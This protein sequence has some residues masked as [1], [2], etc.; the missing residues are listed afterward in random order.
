MS[1]YEQAAWDNSL[2]RLHEPPG[3]GLLPQRAKDAV[4]SGKVAATQFAD[5]HLPVETVKA[6]V[7]KVMD[8]ALE[9]TF[10]PALRTA[11]ADRALKAYQ[12][13]HDSLQS[14]DDLKQL[15][16]RELDKFRRRKGVYIAT[17]AV[18]AS[19]TS[20]VVTG[21]VV[22]TTVS[23]GAT[24]GTVVAAVAGDTV[25]SLAVMGR[26]VGSVAV[27]YGYDVRLPDE[28][29]FAMGVLTLGTAGSLEAKQA[30][31]AALSRLTQ[32]M[33]RRATW[34][35]LNR[36]V[37]VR[38]IGRVYQALGLKLTQRKLAQTVP[39][40]GI[41]INAALSASMTRHVYQRAEDV[42]RV[43]FLSEKYGL[44]ATEWLRMD[45]DGGCDSGESADG[46]DI[47]E[48]LQQ[49]IERSEQAD[50]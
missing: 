43:R 27:R 35:Q 11:N 41:G 20:V 32:Q 25:A 12:R 14:L 18:Q 29:L 13:R 48:V 30:A 10:T 42:Y 9:L 15:D 16:V 33:M 38:T 6:M 22:S 19:A 5:A 37:L 17:S 31:L 8:G 7:E 46:V 40:V 47:A 3:A 36:Q 4:G 50:T 34:E 26:S 23:A 39:V 44:D 2:R 21:S 49:E 24:S 45:G 1:A 28:E